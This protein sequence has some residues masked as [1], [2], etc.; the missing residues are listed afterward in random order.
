MAENLFVRS[1]VPKFLAQRQLTVAELVRRMQ[2]R[3]FRFDKKTI[4]RLASDE[5]MQHLNLPAVAAIGRV[6]NLNDPGKLI[7]WSTGPSVP[8]RLQRI[9]TVTQARLDDLM[10]K[11]TEGTLSV[12]ERRELDKLG[13]LVEKLSLENARLL[14]SHG[15]AANPAVK[16]RASAARK[17]IN[18]RFVL[19]K[20]KAAKTTAS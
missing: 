3:G 6:L 16:T 8:P 15:S 12:A 2:D 10:S 19:S 1:A 7:V 13:R 4:Y 20:R 14:A 5:P 17:R 11:N 18:R 9:D